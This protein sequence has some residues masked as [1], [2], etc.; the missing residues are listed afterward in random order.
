MR[1]LITLALV[2]FSAIAN[3]ADEITVSASAKIAS[4]PVIQS[5]ATGDLKFDMTNAQAVYASGV[6]LVNM[7]ALTALPV[8][9]VSAP[10]YLWARNTATNFYDAN[11]NLIKVWVDI[12]PTND[13]AILPTARLNAGEVWMAPLAPGASI[14]LTAS[15]NGVSF[16]YY[17]ITR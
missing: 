9:S 5:Q 15:T 2:A 17:L 16:Q 7:N 1:R 3:G 12:G 6:V 13:G 14:N 11:T 4:G 8:G 10:G